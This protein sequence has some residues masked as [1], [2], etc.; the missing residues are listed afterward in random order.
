MR[1]PQG[2]LFLTGSALPPDVATLRVWMSPATNAGR[3][4]AVYPAWYPANYAGEDPMLFAPSPA[5]TSFDLPVTSLRN[6]AYELPDAQVPPYGAYSF[7][8]QAIRTDQTRGDA[9]GIPNFAREI[10]PGFSVGQGIQSGAVPFLDGR[11]Q[12]QQNIEFQL[13]TAKGPDAC[14]GLS[15]PFNLEAASD[16]TAHGSQVVYE[17]G[18]PDYVFAGFP[19]HALPTLSPSSLHTLATDV[20]WLHQAVVEM[21]CFETQPPSRLSPSSRS[22]YPEIRFLVTSCRLFTDHQ[23]PNTNH[24]A[25]IESLDHT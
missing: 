17:P 9:V 10:D 14:S 13:R 1:G 24:P 18:S 8:V 21:S 3:A 23:S 11:R 12:I 19:L 5:A 4:V 20:R 16:E 22:R 7:H 2:R 6:G 25:P 15:E